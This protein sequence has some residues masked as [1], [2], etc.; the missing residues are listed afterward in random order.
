MSSKD[1]QHIQYFSYQSGIVSASLQ[2][3]SLSPGIIYL[4]KFRRFAEGPQAL[5]ILIQMRVVSCNEHAPLSIVL[6]FTTAF[7]G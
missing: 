4:R 3:L 7:T 1:M 5:S 2:E 6:S